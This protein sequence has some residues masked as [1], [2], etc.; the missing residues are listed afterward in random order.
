MG[1]QS[2]LLARTINVTFIDIAL[3]VVPVI[4]G[5]FLGAPLIAREFESGTYRFTWTQGMPRALWF[6]LKFMLLAVVVVTAACLLGLFA[7]SYSEPFNAIGFMSHW[8]TGEFDVTGLTLGAWTLFALA[9]GVFIGSLTK[10]VV[11]AM[12]VTGAVAGA[13]IVAVYWKLDIQ[14]FALGAKVMK[15]VPSG[16]G[17]GPLNQFTGPGTAK[18][19]PGS[20]LVRGWYTGPK[21]NVLTTHA[22]KILTI[23]GFENSKTPGVWLAQHRYSYWLSYQPSSRFWFFEGTEAVILVVL[24][25]ALAWGTSA[26]IRRR[27]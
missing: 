16:Q 17:Y 20:W 24:A 1:V 26:V 6:A 7:T 9:L 15:T 14:L 22:E 25:L 23:H 11:S 10:R 27:S 18:A 4:V 3:H 21:G 13:A 2:R 12:A 5:M 19:P 8:Q